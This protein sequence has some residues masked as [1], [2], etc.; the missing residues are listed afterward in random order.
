[1]LLEDNALPSRNPSAAS[2]CEG[3]LQ[4]KA[5]K[6]VAIAMSHFVIYT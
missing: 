2:H 1:M 4:Y 3:V 6:N 5:E